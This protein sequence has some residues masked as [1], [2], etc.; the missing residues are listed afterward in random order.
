MN[1]TTRYISQF[2]ISITA[3]TLVGCGGGAQT[4]TDPTVIEP[5]LPV[6]DWSLVWS[7]EFDT[8]AI[9]T[10]KW[11]HEVNCNGGGNNEKQCYTDSEDN[12]YISDGVLNIVALPAANDAALPYTS[13]RLNTRYKADFKYGRFE[14]RAKLPSGQG[15]WPAF[16]MLPTDEFYGGWPKSGE[17]D[18][19]EAVNLKTENE[20]GDVESRI[21]GTLHYGKDWPDNVSSGKEYILPEGVNP[22]DDFHTY[23]IEKKRFA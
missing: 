6:S 19:L 4:K 14:I 1:K 7:D 5:N 23:A 20:N 11:N 22:A 13:A 2:L 12:S 10:Q 17:I 16:W 9:D 21:Y 15:S 3:I 8:N 18:V